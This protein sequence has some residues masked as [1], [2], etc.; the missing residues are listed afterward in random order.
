MSDKKVTIQPISQS[1]F[2]AVIKLEVEDGD[3]KFVAPNMYS[4][5]EAYIEPMV[6]PMAI[7]AGGTPVGFTL[8]GQFEEDKGDYWIA[9]LMVGKDY[10]RKGY[11][12]NA[13]RLVIED[14]RSAGASEI[15]LSL[16]PG[17]DQARRLYYKLGFED[18]GRVEE[19]EDVLRLP[20]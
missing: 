11:A 9:R 20:L 10:R 4:I 17:N 15:F 14:M 6:K 7:H 2:R 8:Y 12:E 18:T 5:A 3:E 16:V 19:N 13:M 1:N